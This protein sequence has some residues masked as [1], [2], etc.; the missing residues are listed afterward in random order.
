VSGCNRSFSIPVTAEG[1]FED[2]RF[3]MVVIFLMLENGILGGTLFLI[4]GWL[5]THS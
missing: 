4:I 2:T 1:L 3:S 5:K